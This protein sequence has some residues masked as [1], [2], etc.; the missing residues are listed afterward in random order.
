MTELE[1][2]ALLG[3]GQ[4]D[5]DHIRTSSSVAEAE[6]RLVALKDRAKKGYRAQALKLHPDLNGD[7]PEKV[8]VLVALNAL[9]AKLDKMFVHVVPRP[10]PQPVV[11]WVRASGTGF[12]SGGGSSTTTTST[13]W[14]QANIYVN[15][16]RVS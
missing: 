12:G 3:L 4:G 6:A 15:G 9:M 16:M 5:F 13:G 2:I 1:L 10:R 11:H 8:K 14:T 7:D